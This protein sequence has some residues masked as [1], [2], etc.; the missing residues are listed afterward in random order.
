V[1]S[2]F[3]T[4][5][6]GLK[7][8]LLFGM[9][10]GGVSGILRGL[11][12]GFTDLLVYS[13]LFSFSTVVITAGSAGVIR[14]WFTS[15]ELGMANGLWN[16]FFGVGALTAMLLTHSLVIPIAGG[17]RSA[18]MLYASIM[19]I[20]AILWI[21]LYREPATT[22]DPAETYTGRPATKML[23]SLNLWLVITAF[24]FIVGDQNAAINWMPILLEARGLTPDYA[25]LLSSIVWV[26][27]LSGSVV[28][29]TVSDRIRR[30]ILPVIILTPVMGVTIYALAIMSVD[31]PLLPFTIFGLGFT[32]SYAWA[33]FLTIVMELP[34]V[35][36][37]N[38]ARASGYLLSA[39][40]VGAFFLPVLGGFIR[41]VTGSLNPA[42]TAYALS[43]QIA[44]ISL[45]FI[46]LRKRPQSA[47][48]K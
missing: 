25:G 45:A 43:A 39:S 29:P 48:S 22:T 4:D 34:E 37:Q 8:F 32:S 33:M 35:G 11:S 12:Y 2:G 19:L 9:I 7:K 26:G 13:L 30:R 44:T 6:M 17:W 46:G 41:D 36:R 24:L 5:K 18:F 31:S 15:R 1:V 20:A 3:L 40:G 28:I 14:I 23:R 16:A 38:V 27:A 21:F 42:F 10:L 47:V